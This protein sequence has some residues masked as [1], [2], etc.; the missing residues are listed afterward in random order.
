MRRLCI[1]ICLLV[2]PGCTMTD[3]DRR[4]LDAAMADGRGD[5]M[6]MRGDMS[7]LDDTSELPSLRP[8]DLP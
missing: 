5:N 4:Q 2:G 6:R 3:A 1:I 8:R 7:R